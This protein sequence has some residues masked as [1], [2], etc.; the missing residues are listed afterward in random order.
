[1]HEWSLYGCRGGETH[2]MVSIF[3]CIG[4]YDGHTDDSFVKKENRMICD[5]NWCW[6]C[7]CL[8]VLVIDRGRRAFFG[9]RRKGFLNFLS[10]FECIFNR[11]Q[12]KNSLMIL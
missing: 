11:T 3:G 12:E 9:F 10:F 2:S 6:W 4:M 8:K 1:M 5:N 7:V